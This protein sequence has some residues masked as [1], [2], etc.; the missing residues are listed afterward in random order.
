MARRR[1]LGSEP[2]GRNSAM[3]EMV[4]L[5]QRLFKGRGGKTG[6]PGT[7]HESDVNRQAATH[8]V[9]CRPSLVDVDQAELIWLAQRRRVAVP[10]RWRMGTRQSA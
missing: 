6:L 3:A 4:P 5:D 8:T 10:M 1:L 2:G 7:S 9:S